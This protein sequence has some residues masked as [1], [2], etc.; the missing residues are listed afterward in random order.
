MPDSVRVLHNRFLQTPIGEVGFVA[1][2]NAA[3]VNS[4]GE[5]P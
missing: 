4:N 2:L 1:A 5:I 3:P